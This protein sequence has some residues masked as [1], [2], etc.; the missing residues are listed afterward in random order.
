MAGWALVAA[1]SVVAWLVATACAASSREG[2]AAATGELTSTAYI[3]TTE[4]AE[5]IYAACLLLLEGSAQCM[6]AVPA[7]KGSP[8]THPYGQ[9]L[10]PESQKQRLRLLL[11]MRNAAAQL[12]GG[13][14]QADLWPWRKS[15]LA[16]H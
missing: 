13:C 9:Y 15:A 1:R 6:Y 14:K 10:R 3:M 8:A 11:R 12:P 2:A 4:N 7:A 5:Y 16:A